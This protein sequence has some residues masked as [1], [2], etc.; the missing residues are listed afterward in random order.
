MFLV[1]HTSE[2]IRP[3]IDAQFY[4]RIGDIQEGKNFC[5]LPEDLVNPVM[6]SPL[7]PFCY[8]VSLEESLVQEAR[9]REFWISSA[10]SC[11]GGLVSAAITNVSGASEVFPGS[12]TTYSNESKISILGVDKEL[13]AKYGAVSPEVALQMAEKA[14]EKLIAPFFD[15]NAVS[16]GISGIAGPG[17]GSPEKP[18]GLVY[19][20]ICTQSGPLKALGFRFLGDRAAVRSKA[21][22]MA[23]VLLRHIIQ[24]KDLDMLGDW[25][26]ST[27]KEEGVPP[28][29][30]S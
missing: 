8:P 5:I 1:F 13:I 30:S 3:F 25:E 10:E 26:Y 22:D 14:M 29:F 19:F 2:T 12:F 6:M 15:G 16:I 11:T 4:A 17:G 21:C 24:G 18:V 7:S 9:E 27:R 28:F 23:I 20:G